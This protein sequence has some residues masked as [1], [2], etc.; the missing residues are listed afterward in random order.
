MNFFSKPQVTVLKESSDAV[1]YLERLQDILPRANGQLKDKIQREI[2]ITKAG[3]YGENVIL[4]ELR[5]SGM[6]MVVLHDICLETNDGLNA[7]IDYLVLTPKVNFVIECKNLLGN[8]EIDSKGNFIRTTE[9]RGKRIKEGIY[10]PIT[11]NER[12]LNVLKRK[13]QEEKGL[14]GSWIAETTFDECY[15]SLIVLANPHTIVNDR[16]AKKEIKNMVIRADQLIGTLKKISSESQ[17]WASS[18]NA[19]LELARKLL[20][21][22]IE[23]RKD[24][25]EKY[26]DFLQE[27]EEETESCSENEPQILHEEITEDTKEQTEQKTCPRCGAKLVL[28]TAR[29]G[30]RAGQQF[31]G[32]AAFPKCRYVEQIDS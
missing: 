2:E 32:C 28:R 16:Y 7:Q 9:Y 11:Q 31:Y 22:N 23:D 8:V 25:L 30:N 18:K 15:K 10:S 26:K 13:I 29:K 4:Y 24:Y 17:N 6:D 3:I 27:V 14:I 5:N 1:M 12:H 21:N 20:E 19:M